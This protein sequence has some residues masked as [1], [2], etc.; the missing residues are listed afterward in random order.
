MRLVPVGSIKVNSVLANIVYDDQGRILLNKG[1]I[2]TESLIKRLIDNEVLGVHIHDAYSQ[3]EIQ[4]VISPDLRLH[5]V[6]EIRKTFKSIQGQI[7][8]SIHT[9]NHDK[10]KINKKLHLM[11]DQKYL[12]NLDL[13]IDDMINEIT[14]NKDAMIGLV[15]IKNMKAFIYQHSIQVTVLSLLMG[16]ALKLNRNMLK[17]LAICAML[18]DI[19]LTF[20]NK[21]LVIYSKDF[22]DEELKIY[23]SHPQLGYDFIK[24]NTTLSSHVRMGILQHHEEYSGNGY[25]LKLKESN[26]H[27]FGRIIQIANTYDKMSSGLQGGPIAPNEVLEFIMGNSGNGRMFDL[28]I[29]NLFVRKIVPFPIGSHVMLSNNAKAVVVN[30]NADN[31][32]RPMVKILIEGKKIEELKLFNLL[33]HNKLNVTIQ[34]IIYD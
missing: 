27:L 33:D 29:A 17:D 9:M 34:K 14:Y 23:Q 7:D 21:K 20:I 12:Q 4:D 5:A 24:E 8:Q 6:S 31:P 22:S 13:I 3:N 18:H 1:V 15:D 32:L 11:V 19:G 30:Y 25:P 16:A 2:L 26:I 10:S 28:D